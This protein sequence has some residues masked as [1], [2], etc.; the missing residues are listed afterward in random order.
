M[1]EARRNEIAYAVLKNRIKEDSRFKEISNLRR[2]VGEIKQKIGGGFT[3]E[4]LL[5]FGKNI[6][7]EIFE[8]EMKALDEKDKR[9]KKKD[10][11]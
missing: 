10:R 2:K 9:K 3:S 11:K 4:E 8:E 7:R 5:E 6:V 1:E